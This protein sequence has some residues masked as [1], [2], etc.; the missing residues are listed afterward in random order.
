MNL[1]N[2]IQDL[3]KKADMTQEMLAEKLNIS[4]Q[5]IA[6]WEKGESFPD[7]NN[8]ISLSELFG[9]SIDFLLK[10]PNQ[11]SSFSDNFDPSLDSI[12]VF[13]RKAKKNTY[14]AHGAEIPSSRAHSHDLSFKEDP[15]H[16]LDCYFGGEKFAGQ[17][18]LY[19]NNKPYWSMNYLGRTLDQNFSGDF[20]KEA[21]MLVNEQKPFRGPDFHQKGSFFYRCMINGTFDWFKGEEEIFFETTK[22][23]EC[24]FHGGNIR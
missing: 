17:E 3:R 14:A 16:Y 24:V 13:L 22:V 8:L 7:L 20:L 2:R 6:K 11:Y 1:S 10:G 18:I 15:Y 5:S 23:Y 9:V 21:L 4:R 19:V 12:K